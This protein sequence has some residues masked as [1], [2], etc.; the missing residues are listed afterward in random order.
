MT[1]WNAD[2]LP[3]L[4]GRTAVVTGANS[5]LGRVTATA[6]AGAGAR[7]VLAV[8][9]LDRGRTVAATI[10]GDTEVRPLDLADLSSVRRF[11]DSWRGD[12]DLLINNAGVMMLPQ[13]QTKDGFEMQFGT[14]HLGHFALTARLLPIPG[15]KAGDLTT[16]AAADGSPMAGGLCDSRVMRIAN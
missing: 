5:G 4:S 2:R 1:A 15:L 14:N 10:S 16:F 3:D 13:Q 8:R 6:L 12:L 11:A 7:V 9:D